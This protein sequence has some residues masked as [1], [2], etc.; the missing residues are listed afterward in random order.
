MHIK[1]IVTDNAYAIG[2]Y[3]W[4]DSATYSND[5]LLEIGFDSTL[6]DRYL[7]IIKK[8]LIINQ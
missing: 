8:I 1:S 3:N 7:E 5:E 2:S 4:T 6:H